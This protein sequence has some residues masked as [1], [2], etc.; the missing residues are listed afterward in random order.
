VAKAV[1]AADS[2]QPDWIPAGDH[3]VLIVENDSHQPLYEWDRFGIPRQIELFST[4]GGP[5]TFEH[6]IGE[7]TTRPAVEKLAQRMQGR[8][9]R[10]AIAKLT[11]VAVDP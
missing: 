1:A 10:V 6:Y 11:F 4:P 5:I 8:Y 3:F 7:R 2:R 9:G